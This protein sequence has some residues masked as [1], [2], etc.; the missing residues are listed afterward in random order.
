MEFFNSWKKYILLLPLLVLGGFC[1]YFPIAQEST[2]TL[3][4]QEL[5]LERQQSIGT[6]CS[7]INNFIAKNPE[8]DGCEETLVSIIEYI[9]QNYKTTFAQVYDHDLNALTKV[10]PGARGGQKHDP[11]NYSQFISAVTAARSGSGQGDLVYWYENPEAGGRDV[12][13]SFRWVPMSRDVSERYL[14]VLGVSKYSINSNINSG[15]Q[16]GAIALIFTTS[17]IV[18]MSIVML[19]KL[20]R[21]YESRKGPNKWRGL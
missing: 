2:E 17:V 12:Y 1:I 7:V 13:I 21:I 14:V 15:L 8:W 20:G 6:I 19:T 5:A 16:K 18:I 3:L 10:S 11:L 9:D 4:V